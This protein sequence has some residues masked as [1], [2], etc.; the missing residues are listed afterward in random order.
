VITEPLTG[1]AEATE[2]PITVAA[3]NA[4]MVVR[5]MEGVLFHIRCDPRIGQIRNQANLQRPEFNGGLNASNFM[6]PYNGA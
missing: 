2:I 1:A 5:N 3:A 6:P 4:I